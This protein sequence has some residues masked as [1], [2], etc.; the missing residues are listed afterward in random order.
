M[1]GLFNHRIGLLAQLCGAVPGPGPEVPQ[2]TD[3]RL[4]FPQGASS[5]IW[6]REVE[7]RGTVDGPQL[8]IH[9]TTGTATASSAFAG[10]GADEA[11]NGTTAGNGWSTSNESV[12]GEWIAFAF[13]TAQSLA[14]VFIHAEPDQYQPPEVTLQHHD[15]A[16]WVDVQTWATPTAAWDAEA[17]NDA[18][19]LVLDSTPAVSGYAVTVPAANVGASLTGF[20]LMIDLSDMPASFWNAVLANGGN[21]RVYASDGTTLIPHDLTYINASRKLGRLFART[22]LSASANTTV[23]VKLD[24]TATSA[25]PATDANGRNAVWLDY[26]VV[27]VFPEDVNRTGK[28]YPQGGSIVAPTEWKRDLYEGLTGSPHQ[29]LS[30]ESSGRVITIDTDHLR[31][32]DAANLATTLAE[33]SVPIADSGI[34]GVN[35]LG[36][37]CVIG[38]ELFVPLEEYPNGPYDNQHIAVY[39]ADTLAFLRSYDISANGHEVSGIAFDGTDLWITDFTDD[40]VLYRYSTTGTL[41]ET[42]ALSETVANMQGLTHVDGVFYVSSDTARNAVKAVAPDGTVTGT[43]MERPGLSINEGVALDGTNFWLLRGDGNVSRY[44]RPPRQADWRRVFFDA[45]HATI[46][47]R[48]DVWTMATSV[49]WADTTG[50]LQQG[51]LSYANGTSYSNRAT[52]AYDDGPDVI[53]T[54]N[55]SDSWMNSTRNPGHNDVFRPALSHD[56]TAGRTLWVDGVLEASEGSSSSRPS[57]SG[58]AAEFIINASEH[59]ATEDGE[60]YY[61]FAWLRHEVMSD[62]WMAADGDNMADPAAFYNIT[63]T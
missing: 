41:L 5:Y 37:G 9:G 27:W 11:F 10:Y 54:W 3:W 62:A 31:R 50:D 56:G 26:E 52:L 61:Q 30:V 42:V 51:F 35:H 45:F 15:G 21:V 19:S 59:D 60:A 2:A 47:P 7:F 28:A 39:D 46:D 18:I 49:R 23:V 25:L 8:A 57:G 43:V 38:N 33:N 63:E 14:E 16:G 53:A 29:G 13:D 12:P 58:T 48:S 24:A 40:T 6:L 4:H 55:S 36:D 1:A 20:P 34:A 44:A 17:T 32:H 22:D